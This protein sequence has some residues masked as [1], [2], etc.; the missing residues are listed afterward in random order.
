MEPI[1]AAPRLVNQVYE[2]V[3]SAITNGRFDG[4]RRL[5]QE[6]IATELGVSRQPV[7]QALL[8]LR[9]QGLL[10]DAP[11]RGLMLAPFDLHHMLNLYEIRATLDGLAARKAASA[12]SD[13]TK[14]GPELI[15]KGRAA[16][17]GGS[18]AQM[19][20][21][22]INFHLFLYQLS[23][24]PLIAESSANHWSYLRRVMA[25]VLMRGE[26]PRE[27]WDQHEEILAAVIARDPDNAER[28]AKMHISHAAETLASR[29][30]DFGDESSTAANK[31][32][33]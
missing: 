15:E 2:A 19:I 1:T 33:K 18:V 27:I 24:N 22:D 12:S 28:L 11:G 13:L 3:L 21:A 8:L 4:D 31:S 6:D 5:I 14:Q 25:E 29:M 17:Q 20:A 23:G 30:A 26:T 9:S 32:P 16:I 10:R 7:Q